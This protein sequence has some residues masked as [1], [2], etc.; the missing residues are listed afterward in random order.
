M[1]A[2]SFKNKNSK[3]TIK[4]KKKT[5]RLKNNGFINLFEEANYF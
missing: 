5:Y 4:N 3:E 2:V 1:R